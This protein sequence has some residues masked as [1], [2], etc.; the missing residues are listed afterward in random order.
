MLVELGVPKKR[1]C[2][3]A[4]PMTGI[5]EFNFPM[6]HR[7]AGYMRQHGWEVFDPAERDEKM[8]DI[9]APG[10]AEGDVKLWAESAGFDFRLAMRWDLGVITTCEAM[11]L[12]P[13]WEKSSGVA[14][15]KFVAETCGVEILYA[16][17]VKKQY[18]RR[19]KLWLVDWFV[20][21]EYM[22]EQTPVE[23]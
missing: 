16:Y 18:G 14:N 12:L 22:P 8:Y 1:R 15:E 3:I 17:P 21:T 19:K 2:Y 7:L 20:S 11:V 10:Y 6:F 9:K 5:P 23:V 13:G 4:G